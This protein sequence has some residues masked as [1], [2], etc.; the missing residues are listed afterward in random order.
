MSR[1]IYKH[2]VSNN[3]RGL[4]DRIKKQI[5]PNNKSR[6]STLKK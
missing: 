1:K 4:S 3:Y 6:K 5:K 2:L